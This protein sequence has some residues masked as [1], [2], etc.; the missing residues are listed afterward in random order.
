MLNLFLGPTGWRSLLSLV[1]G[2][3]QVNDFLCD[4]HSLV[5]SVEMTCAGRSAGPP[6][7]QQL[8]T[9][10]VAL[11]AP[12]LALSEASGVKKRCT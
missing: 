6:S 10:L 1:S 5:K 4:Q 7:D 12:P 9:L 11:I 8:T 3:I 2:G